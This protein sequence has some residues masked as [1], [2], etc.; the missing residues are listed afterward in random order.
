M[1]LF[2]QFMGDSKRTYFPDDDIPLQAVEATARNR[3]IA[4]EKSMQE[5]WRFHRAMEK[6]RGQRGQL[7]WS[8]WWRSS[9]CADPA[10]G[11]QIDILAVFVVTTDFSLARYDHENGRV[12]HL[13]K[14]K[15][16]KVYGLLPRDA[17]G[18]RDLSQYG[19]ETG[20]YGWLK[21]GPW[22]KDF[23]DLVE[24]REAAKEGEEAQKRLDIEAKD[25][26]VDRQRAI[27]LDSYGRA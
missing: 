14:D 11:M 25:A 18:R 7:V 26:E 10:D 17:T 2:K 20:P 13:P 8:E 22:I 1:S 23:L 21:E 24:E 9:G 19:Y 15:A 3:A 5:A 6:K 27:I 4:E 12:A 16:V